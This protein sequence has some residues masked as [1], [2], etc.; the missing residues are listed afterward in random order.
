MPNLGCHRDPDYDT[1]ET[2]DL[3]NQDRQIESCGDAVYFATGHTRYHNQ[4]QRLPSIDMNKVQTS[5]PSERLAIPDMGSIPLFPASWYRFGP[6]TEIRQGPKSKELCGQKLVAF[7]ASNGEVAVM[8]GRCSHMRADL[9]AGRVVG[10]NLECPFHQW[11]YGLDGIC[12]HIPCNASPPPTAKQ[13]KYTTQVRHGQIYFF[14]GEEPTFELPFY[15]GENPEAFAY[16]HVTTEL[17]EAPWYMI[18]INSVDIQHFRVAHDRRLVS[19]PKIEHPAP[20]AHRASY[21]FEIEGT[22]WQDRLTRF[23]GG[24]NVHLEITEWAGNIVLA[25]ATLQRAQTFGMLFLEPQ[26]SERTLVHIMVF[27]RR[28]QTLVG[29]RLLDAL[30]T[31]IRSYLVCR[32]LRSDISRMK[33][34]YVQP[35]RLIEQDQAVAD[36]MR[37][38]CQLPSGE[39]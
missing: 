5:I 16:S 35:H 37:F 4:N 7:Q 36:Y 33:G 14:L 24:P 21:I 3:K 39:A 27:A 25:R 19:E 8:E 2:N 17:V 30:R 6:L 1:K 10:D 32:F 12:R 22:S 31:S 28:S 38:L 34:G 18:S 9:G 20:L 29:Q 13:K 26:S 15:H 11:H 23:A